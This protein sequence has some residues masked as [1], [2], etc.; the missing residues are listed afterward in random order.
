MTRT[1]KD[2]AIEHGGY[3]ADAAELYMAARR[4]HDALLEAEETDPNRLQASAESL[5]D[6]WR[7]LNEGIYEFRK[8][9]DRASREDHAE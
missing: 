7:A 9:A 6:H 3:L 8:R 5:R 2:Y 4:S 1:A